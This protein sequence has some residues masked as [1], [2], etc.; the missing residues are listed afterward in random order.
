MGWLRELMAASDPPVQSY[1]DLARRCLDHRDWPRDIQPQAR[2]LASLFSKFD[3]GMEVEWLAERREVQHVLAQTLGLN[4]KSVEQ[5]VHKHLGHADRNLHRFR[6]SDA[7]NARPIDLREESLP[8]VFDERLLRPG[9][10]EKYW[11]SAQTGCGQELLSAWLHARALADVTTCA[12]W[13]EVVGASQAGVVPLFVEYTG[14]PP[15]NEQVQALGERPLCLVHVAPAPVGFTELVSPSLPDIEEAL[16]TWLATLWVQPAPVSVTELRAW[17]ARLR[18]G[19]LG[20]TLDAM[21]GLVGVAYQ[22]GLAAVETLS[23][24][25]LTRLFLTKAIEQTSFVVSNE[26]AWLK[27]NVYEVLR[28][29][30]RNA[31]A[32][33]TA[34]WNTPL[35]QADWLTLVPSEYQRGVD[36]EWTRVS[37]QQ[38]G[39]PLTVSELE[40]ALKAVP[41]GGFR[42]IESLRTA[43]LLRQSHDAKLTL[44]PRWVADYFEAAGYASLLEESADSWGKVALHPERVDGIVRALDREHAAEKFR[45]LDAALEL[46]DE[47]TPG[48]ALAIELLVLTV[49]RQ[50]L[51]GKELEPEQVSGLLRLQQQQ[52]VYRQVAGV[53]SEAVPSPRLLA[54]PEEL[55]KWGAWLLSVWALCEQAPDLPEL[56]AL[57]PWGPKPAIDDTTVLLVSRALEHENAEVI[58][59]AYQMLGRLLQYLEGAVKETPSLAAIAQACLNHPAFAAARVARGDAWDAWEL[60]LKAPLGVET[61]RTLL[62]DEAWPNVA[63]TAWRSWHEHGAPLSGMSLFARADRRALFWPHLQD[64]VL[65]ALLDE[66]HPIVHQV[67]SE[68]MKAEWVTI[69]LERVPE[70]TELARQ[71]LELIPMAA[72]TDEHFEVLFELLEAHAFAERVFGLWESHGPAAYERLVSLLD[73]GKSQQARV[74]LTTLPESQFAPLVEHLR[75]QLER[76]GTRYPSFEACRTWL[77]EVCSRRRPGWLQTYDLFADMELRLKRVARVASATITPADSP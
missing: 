2:S 27:D 10:W 65:R 46:D 49:G 33:R 76:V 53:S 59:G 1:G 58:A 47:S 42:V 45:A 38:A 66:R 54:A 28:G 50:L 70:Q 6:F 9:L 61:V 36:A 41:P 17:L 72:I 68:C 12:T 69:Y 30:A 23:P 67:P 19:G 63:K 22:W 51:L 55:G 34:P 18:E 57:N 52:V 7:V 31:L 25:E 15:S 73:A 26:G 74:W 48:Y 40:K 3:R 75:I 24:L 20:T 71:Y 35:A 43:Q 77:H 11:W 60:V 32:L 16:I 4:L 5:E 44:K 29:L 8:A 37:L 13:Q 64:R 21:I 39:A 62:S 56:S 14:A